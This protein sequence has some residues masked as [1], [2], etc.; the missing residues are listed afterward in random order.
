LSDVLDGQAV[1]RERFHVRIARG[2]DFHEGLV[3]LILRERAGTRDTKDDSKYNGM[4]D[5]DHGES[6][7]GG[8]LRKV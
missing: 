5:C 2:E 1:L 8:E 3:V 7:L 4:P 6:L